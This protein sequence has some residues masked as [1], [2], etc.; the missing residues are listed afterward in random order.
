MAARL[1]T[2]VIQITTVITMMMTDTVD[3][4]LLEYL[5][6]DLALA[7]AEVPLPP[8]PPLPRESRGTVRPPA[9]RE[10]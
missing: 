9:R 7:E 4:I 2:F 5:A 8:P 10:S 1:T 3:S 6:L